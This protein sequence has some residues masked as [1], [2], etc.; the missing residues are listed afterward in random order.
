[1]TAVLGCQRYV[2]LLLFWKRHLSGKV[3]DTVCQ[4][5]SWKHSTVRYH[6]CSIKLVYLKRVEWTL[7]I[8]GQV[9]CAAATGFLQQQAA[10]QTN[11]LG[12]VQQQKAGAL[13]HLSC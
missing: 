8:Q 12:T 1:M 3:C 7:H 9:K 10:S 13:C 6:S 4:S 5:N 11:L 2:I